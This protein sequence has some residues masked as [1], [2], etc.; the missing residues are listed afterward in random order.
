VVQAATIPTQPWW[1]QVHAM[2]NEAYLSKDHSVFPPSWTRLDSDL[3]KGANALSAELGTHGIFL[4]VFDGEDNPVA[5]SGTLPFRGATW[6]NEAFKK[7]DT[8]LAR[9]G[10]VETDS[11]STGRYPDWETCCFCVHSAQRGRSLAR[12]LVDELE[13]LV[14]A[15]GAKRLI[16]NY[17][18]DE[19]GSFW[20]R[21][22][23]VVVPDAGGMLPKGFT[24]P[25]GLEG[26]RADVHFNMAAKAI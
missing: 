25:G 7:S 8:E 1:R 16:S 22:G 26:L 19:T 18:T 17:A 12:K 5:C 11:S 3:T 15:R 2:I 23:F 10:L 13:S 4:V 14:K 6:M 9:A 20:P 21:L 24:R